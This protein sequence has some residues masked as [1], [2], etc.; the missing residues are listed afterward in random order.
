MAE[1]T[2]G[3]EMVNSTSWYVQTP[4]AGTKPRTARHLPTAAAAEGVRPLAL[5]EILGSAAAM[6][7]RSYKLER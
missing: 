6:P 1:Y 4:G 7:G 5:R 2:L 3:I